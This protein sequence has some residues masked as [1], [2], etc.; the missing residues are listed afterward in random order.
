MIRTGF[1]FAV[2]LLLTLLGGCAAVSRQAPFPRHYTLA[3]ATRPTPL[4]RQPGPAA[5]RSLQVARIVAAPWLQDTGIHY[6]LEYRHDHSIASYANSDWVASPA[7]LLEEAVQNALAAN[8][9]WRVVVGPGS[10]ARTDFS[11]Q[12]RLDDFAQAFTSP[13][14]SRG[15]LDATATLIDNRDERAI[16]QRH[17]HVETEAPSADAAGGVQALG[18]AGRRFTMQ[19]AGWLHAVQAAAP[20]GP[21][22]PPR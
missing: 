11:L 1:A 15:V 8:G 2:C 5:Q 16:A 14:Q 3:G 18:E 22:T 21:A 17:F 9:A 12:I 20:S 7:T 19:L 4:A 6:R 10:P 13:G